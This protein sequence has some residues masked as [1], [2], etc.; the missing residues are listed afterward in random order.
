MTEPIRRRSE[1]TR[2]VIAKRRVSDGELPVIGPT[3]LP[4][5]VPHCRAWGF[6]NGLRGK[7]RVTKPGDPRIWSIAMAGIA[8][9]VLLTGLPQMFEL[10]SAPLRAHPLPVESV[11]LA[12]IKT[13]VVDANSEHGAENTVTTES[14]TNDNGDQFLTAPRSVEFADFY[15]PG[16]V[17]NKEDSQQASDSL[18]DDGTTL[19]H[20]QSSHDVDVLLDQAKLD[21]AARR[22]TT[23][24][25]SSAWDRF[26]Q[27][28]VLEPDNIRANQGLQLII[29]RYVKL[30]R[31]AKSVGD[32]LR[33]EVYLARAKSVLFGARQ[34]NT[35]LHVGY[36]S[37]RRNSKRPQ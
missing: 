35:Q 24:T 29:S 5:N 6:S 1:P 11:T 37:G 33:A 36:Q 23:P 22:L 28:L 9:I 10:R 19:T 16:H 34:T 31:D 25:G 32:S 21:L 8:C 17:V 3:R 27:V 7:P 30:A 13:S 15:P 2:T 4:F 14:T 20:R 12:S 18:I 26:Q